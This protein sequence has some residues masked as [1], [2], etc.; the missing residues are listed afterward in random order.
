MNLGGFGLSAGEIPSL[1][2]A[3][4]AIGIQ[5]GNADIL[6]LGGE[7]RI[8]GAAA[9][10]RAGMATRFGPVSVPFEKV[11]AVF[12]KRRAGRARI[13]LR[14]GRTFTGELDLEGLRFTMNSGPTMELDAEALDVLVLRSLPE[15]AS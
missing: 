10:V 15:T 7:T 13:Y 4:E 1:D 12:G 8:M 2:K 14:D 3:L 5:R 9:C 11:A 6:A